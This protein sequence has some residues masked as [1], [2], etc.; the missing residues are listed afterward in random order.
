MAYGRRK[1]EGKDVVIATGNGPELTKECLYHTDG[2]TAHGGVGT[3]ISGPRG[4]GKTTLL[5]QFTE[6]VL[7]YPITVHDRN[8]M[9]RMYRETAIYRVRKYDYWNTFFPEYWEHMFPEWKPKPVVLHQHVDN[10]YKFVTD[11][12]GRISPLD[13]S[14][15][16]VIPYTDSTELILDNLKKGAINLVCEP[17]DYM[18][19][20]D[21]VK[22]LQ[23]K[24]L[25]FKFGRDKEEEE[26]PEVVRDINNPLST[27]DSD[28]LPGQMRKVK[29]SRSKK[30]DPQ[31]APSPVWWFE[32]TDRVLE[33]KPQ[34]EFVSFFLDELHQI[35]PQYS[36]SLHFHLVGW[37]ATATL[38]QRRMNVSL[39]GVS[40]DTTLI[41]YRIKRR[42]EFFVY[43][44]GARPDDNSMV[45]QSLTASLVKGEYVIERPGVKYGIDTFDRFIDQPP[46]IIAEGMQNYV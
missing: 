7:H 2:Q 14:E 35:T 12:M 11:E 13:M 45:W 3:L 31:P 10:N 34:H 46:V 20:S 42:M 25:Q 41:D 9:K 44:P 33:L 27:P 22:S 30:Y 4:G 29:K 39:F 38:D 19:P 17:K 6:G 26:N 23:L 8:Y 16:E 18:I 43:T 40:H 32:L 5:D 28:E 24:R 36:M 37:Y 21:I 15:I 1:V